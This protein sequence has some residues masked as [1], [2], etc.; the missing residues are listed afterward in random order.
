MYRNLLHVTALTLLFFF[1]T[2]S[3]SLT[4]ES[5][6]SINQKCPSGAEVNFTFNTSQLQALN[7]VTV[8]LKLTSPDG[9][10]ITGAQVYCS[11]YMPSYATGANN[12]KLTPDNNSGSYKGIVF[13]SQKGKW[14][15]A[16]TINYKDGGYEE[17]MLEIGDVLPESG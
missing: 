4:A 11:L 8:N 7:P 5:S 15:A 16:L 9:V 2:I 3:N 13:F 6:L 10:P 14:V 12:P 1:S 17:V